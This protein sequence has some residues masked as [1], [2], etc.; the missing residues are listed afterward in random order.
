MKNSPFIHDLAALI[1]AM[2]KRDLEAIQAAKVKIS[3]AIANQ[4]MHKYASPKR[5]YVLE[6]LRESFDDRWRDECGY[7]PLDESNKR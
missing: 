6:S 1:D 7:L 3:Q 4:D 5:D 2:K